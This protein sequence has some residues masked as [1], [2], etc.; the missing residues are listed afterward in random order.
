MSSTYYAEDYAVL[1]PGTYDGRLVRVDE[2]KDDGAYGPILRWTFEVLGDHP[3]DD[4]TEIQGI[5]SRKFT[6][7]TKA[8]LWYESLIG[9][10]LAKGEAIDL[11]AV[12]GTPVRLAVTVVEKEKGTF[13][14]IVS[15]TRLRRQAPQPVPV[16]ADEPP[17]P[18]YA[19]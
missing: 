9:A 8:R 2:P 3:G 6:P 10:K 13:N 7:G 1:D 5:T 18:A 4:P 17:L 15:V 19:G 16:E 12:E 11:E 14:Q